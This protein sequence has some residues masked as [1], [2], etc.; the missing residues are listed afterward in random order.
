MAGGDLSCNISTHLSVATSPLQM[1]I[2]LF[3][4]HVASIVKLTSEG[5]N[6]TIVDNVANILEQ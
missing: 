3:H 2:L 6:V 5:S 4:R 1:R